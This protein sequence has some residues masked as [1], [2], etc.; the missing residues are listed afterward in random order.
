MFS[1]FG[2]AGRHTGPSACCIS[3]RYLRSLNRSESTSEHT[4]LRRR[5]TGFRDCA[6]DIAPIGMHAASA[7]SRGGS[8]RCRSHARQHLHTPAV[9]RT[10]A[11][12]A[13]AR[14]REFYVRASITCPL[15][16][17]YDTCPGLARI[18]RARTIPLAPALSTGPAPVCRTA[19]SQSLPRSPRPHSPVAAV[20]S[21]AVPP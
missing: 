10:T 12:P 20:V 6:P 19:A 3:G 8:V 17:N 7:F 21:T 14:R 13:A 2:A 15:G 5:P 9:H 1:L 11:S 4:L 16:V 18:T